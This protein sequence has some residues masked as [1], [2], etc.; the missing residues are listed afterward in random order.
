MEVSVQLR[1]HTLW[2]WAWASKPTSELILRKDQWA[3]RRFRPVMQPHVSKH[4]IEK[5][6]H[7]GSAIAGNR[8]LR[9]CLVNPIRMVQCGLDHLSGYV[10]EGIKVRVRLAE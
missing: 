1:H 8:S 3:Q 9:S 2:Y 4:S 5:A 6:G 7:L 10:G